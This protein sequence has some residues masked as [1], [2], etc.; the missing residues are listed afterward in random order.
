MENK[1]FKPKLARYMDA[2]F[3]II[4]INTFEEDKVDSIIKEV[5]KGKDIVEWNETMGFIDMETGTPIGE[6]FSLET[7]LDRY[8]DNELF[9]R[10]ILVLKDI[11]AYLDDPRIVSKIK[12]LV[13]LISQGVD[14][15]III[16]SPVSKF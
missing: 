2:G 12:G 5:G 11:N 8:K 15:N 14:A 3:P 16:V 4:Y 10:Q 9:D 1:S 6:D 7:T 13:R